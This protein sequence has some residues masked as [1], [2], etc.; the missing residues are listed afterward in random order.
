[1]NGMDAGGARGQTPGE[2]TREGDP[3]MPAFKP[4]DAEPG[5]PPPPSWEPGIVEV[6]FREGVRPEVQVAEADAPP[7]FSSPTDADMTPLN[8]ILRQHRLREVEPTF[9]TSPESA[10]AAQTVA[11]RRGLETPNLRHFVTLQIGRA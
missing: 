3:G 11:Q 2:H 6:Q 10:E 7:Q 4:S 8:R 9:E 5:T 1:M